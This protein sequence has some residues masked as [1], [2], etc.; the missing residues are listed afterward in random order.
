MRQKKAKA[1]SSYEFM[2][3]FTG[4]RKAVKF[5]EKS[6]WPEGVTCPDCQSKRI[7]ERKNR[8]GVYQCKDCRNTFTV[9]TGTVFE[10]SKV[11]LRKWLYVVYLLQ[12]APKGVSSLQL[13]KQIGVTQKTAWFM[14]HR[15]REA[16]RAGSFKMS[17]N[18]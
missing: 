6:R 10:K 17:G 13:S 15:L 2:H 9:Q 8:L 4:K 3:K 16:C 18:V 5:Y 7:A 12:T 11:P 14:L 1:L